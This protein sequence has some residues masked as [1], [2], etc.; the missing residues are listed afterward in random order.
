MLSLI[1]QVYDNV[2]VNSFRAMCGSLFQLICLVLCYNVAVRWVSGVF[3]HGLV[4]TKR[5]YV[6][7]E[8]LTCN[9]CT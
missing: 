8:Q 1:F 6:P 7:Y 2:A 9:R 4:G 5:K 3:I